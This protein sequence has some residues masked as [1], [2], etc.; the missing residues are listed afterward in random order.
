MFSIAICDDEKLIRNQVVTQLR[1]SFSYM[2]GSLRIDVFE[3]GTTLLES[4]NEGAYYDMAILDIE[5]PGM[6]GMQLSVQLK[7]VF[8]DILIVYLTA[9]EQYVYESFRTQ[10]FR[11]IPKSRMLPM[12]NQAIREAIAMIELD[13]DKSYLL[14]TNQEIE[15]IPYRDIVY[16]QKDGKYVRFI[17]RSGRITKERKTLKEV[18]DMLDSDMFVWIDRGCVC[19]LDYI[20][21]VKEG[22]VIMYDDVELQ[23]SKERAQ[24]IQDAMLDYYIR[25]GRS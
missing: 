25:I 16:I 17:R 5:M 18:K 2:R 12:L 22:S 24:D 10:P 14:K 23:A 1:S 8:Q 3:D 11:F 21:H 7:A 19:N 6:S 15:R 4:V 13:A 20:Q 9:H